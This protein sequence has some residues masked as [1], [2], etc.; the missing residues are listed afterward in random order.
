MKKMSNVAQIKDHYIPVNY[1]TAVP[2]GK[3]N[4]MITMFH[5][6]YSFFIYMYTSIQSI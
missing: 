5:L 1:G 2:A 4:V 6:Y 3:D